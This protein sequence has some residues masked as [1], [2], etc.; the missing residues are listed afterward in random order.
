MARADKGE[1][2]IG[3]SVAFMQLALFRET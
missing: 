3:G 2:G 1:A